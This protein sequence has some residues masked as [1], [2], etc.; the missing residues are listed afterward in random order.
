M[1]HGPL[2]GRVTSD[3]SH[4]LSTLHAVLGPVLVAVNAAAGLWGLWL[5]WRAEPQPAF[6]TVLRTGQALLVVQVIL[7]GATLAV[8]REPA[9]LH[10]LY[11]LLPLG[12]SFVA[13]QLRLVAADQV[14]DRRGLASAR[15]MENLPPQEQRVV[16]LEIVRRETGVMAASAI[17][18]ALLA[19]RA[20]G[21]AGG[22]PL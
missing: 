5:W 6:W 3:E 12:V 10:L 4:Q 17:V 13:E 18:V 16:V 21:V 9:E 22:L 19:L 8:G 2:C 14:L 1:G 15:E 7:G 20:S 11:G